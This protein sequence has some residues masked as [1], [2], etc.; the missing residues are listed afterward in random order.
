MTALTPGPAA[1][2]SRDGRGVL[3]CDGA[4]GTM[5]HAAGAALDRSLPELNLSDPRLVATIHESYLSAGADI[6]QTN[7]FGANR[8][9][10][11]DHGFRQRG[12]EPLVVRGRVRDVRLRQRP[13]PER[14]RHRLQPP[15]E[16][17]ARR[18]SHAFSFRPAGAY[19][20]T[21]RPRTL[22]PPGRRSR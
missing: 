16:F 22:R 3:V 17:P 4:N 19:S 10:L 9:W 6:I 1:V 8:L 12:V 2:T 13:G 5:L 15:P 21:S 7:T 18:L 20:W 11:G 14:L